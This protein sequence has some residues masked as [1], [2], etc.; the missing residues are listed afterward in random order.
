MK[1]FIMAMMAFI[2]MFASENYVYPLS[3]T[4]F[5]VQDCD[6]ERV[7]DMTGKDFIVVSISQNGAGVLYA[8]DKDG[9]VWLNGNISSGAK[10]YKTPEGKFKI[11]Y[12]KRFNMSTKYPDERGI[13]NMDYSMFFHQGFA[14]HLGNPRAL[15]HGCIHL[16]RHE[17]D[18]LFK[19]ARNGVSV[20]VTRDR[21]HPF[22][23][24][25]TDRYNLF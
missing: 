25:D 8:V 20:L 16:G 15:S 2:T 7:I 9:T 5:M 1:V 3:K 12:K 14:I 22:A 21:Y 18:S 24:E 17:V 6:T 13:N 10:G 4:E 11:Y 23:R 19:W